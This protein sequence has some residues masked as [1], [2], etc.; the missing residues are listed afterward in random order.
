MK[1]YTSILKGYYD[2][3][4]KVKAYDLLNNN[5]P[6]NFDDRPDVRQRVEKAINTDQLLG[7]YPRGTRNG[8]DFL[9][10]EEGEYLTTSQEFPTVVDHR[11]WLVQEKP[12]GFIIDD[13]KWK[14]IVRCIEKE[15]NLMMVGPSGCGKTQIVFE[16]G[17]LMGRPVYY[18]NL[19][20]TQDPRATLIGST[21]L[22]VNKGTFFNASS[23][24]RAITTPGAIILL[25][26]LSRANPE[27]WNILMSVL[28]PNIRILRL[29]EQPQSPTVTVAP[30]VS[31]VATANT[32]IEYT[33]ARVLDRAL[34]DRFSVIEM[35]PL[36]KVELVKLLHN[37]FPSLDAELKEII[38]EISE[39]ILKETQK[40]DA[41]LTNYLSTRT[42]LE[43]AEL[44]LDGFSLADSAEL[45]IYPLFDSEG[46]LQSERIYCR[47]LVQKFL[48]VKSK[49]EVFTKKDFETLDNF[50]NDNV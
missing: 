22:D 20:S 26:E 43:I 50:K 19:G 13:L 46:D 34:V 23:F 25:D 24:V 6:F 40:E 5:A 21:Q 10:F 32:G 11:P 9:S 42:I 48:K 41:K 49:S 4:G 29:D 15:K 38:S 3:G 45:L 17:E 39:K 44:L 28:D 37:R 2:S 18:F 16:A 8:F 47:Q 33:S 12:N 35:V 31:F 1:E 27:A 30:N 14:F 7:I 36:S